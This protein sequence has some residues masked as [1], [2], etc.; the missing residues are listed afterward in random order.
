MSICRRVEER[1][2]EPME[3]E[4]LAARVKAGEPGTVLELWEAVRRFVEMK[5]RERA[6]AGGRVPLEDL[7]QDGFLAVL[8]AAEQ[9]DP[10]K[11]NAAFLSLLSLTLRKRWAEEAGTRST[12]RDALQ[13]S[14]S[15]D[16]PAVAGDEDSA[17]AVDLIADEGAAL[18]FTGVEYL[19]FL[20]YCRRMIAAALDTLP[21]VQGALLRLH[22]LE[23]RSLEDAAPLCGLSCKQ[24]AS[25]TEFRALLRLERGKYRRE[26]R[27]CLEAFE[28]FRE[29]Q[30]A[31]GRETWK[32]TGLSRTEAGALVNVGGMRG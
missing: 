15:L 9:Y 20:D 7:T 16:A 24:A 1:T 12:R 6:R 5:A 23:G 10:G 29:Y 32:R 17:P 28:D 30:E 27:D 19:D 11:E 31:A 2:A 22:Y 4:E 25:D 14:D 26:L 21:P 18:A 3:L 13:Y 8:D